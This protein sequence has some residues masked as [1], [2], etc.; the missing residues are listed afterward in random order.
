MVG[1]TE[2]MIIVIDNEFQ[3]QNKPK[4]HKQVIIN[5]LDIK[6]DIISHVSTKIT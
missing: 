1:T 6:I 3:T 2:F 4:N 5:A